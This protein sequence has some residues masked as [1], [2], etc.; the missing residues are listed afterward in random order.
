MVG[1]IQPNV[2]VVFV[3]TAGH[4]VGH[5]GMEIFLHNNPPPP[6]RTLAWIHIGASIACY[7][8]QKGADGKWIT[9]KKLELRRLLTSSASTAALTDAA[10]KDQPFNRAITTDKAPPGELREVWGAKYQNFFGIA[11]GHRFFHNPTDSVAVTGP[12]ILEPVARGLA[13]VIATLSQKQR[14]ALGSEKK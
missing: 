13:S 3:A 12:E 6:E 5:G 7:D 8:F 9:D 14:A 1:A 2:N 4:E 11:A 10:F